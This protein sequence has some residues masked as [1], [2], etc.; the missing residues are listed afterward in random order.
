LKDGYSPTTDLYFYEFRL[1]SISVLGNGDYS[2]MVEQR[3]EGEMHALSLD[4]S[5]AQLE[6][7]LAGADPQV[8]ASVRAEL[9]KDPISARTIELDGFVS[10]AARARLGRLEIGSTNE[11]FV[12]LVAQEI[13]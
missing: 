1:H 2:T 3:Y 13:L 12:P 10:F 11:Q 6:K 8:E 9:S 4:F 7:I 5:Q